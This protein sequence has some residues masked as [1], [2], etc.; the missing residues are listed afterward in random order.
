MKQLIKSLLLIAICAMPAFAM[1]Q[2]ESF[3]V[4]TS[5]GQAT[6]QDFALAYCSQFDAG[7][8]EHQALKGFKNGNSNHCDV[9]IENGYARFRSREYSVLNTLEV[10][11]WNLKKN[12]EKLIAVNRVSEGGDGLDES[13]LEFYRYNAKTGVMKRTKAPFVDAPRPI[14][15]V[16]LSV[17]SDELVHE[18]KSAKN[19][20]A[21][22]YQPIFMLPREGQD[23]TFRMA[24]PDAIPK[25]LQRVCTLIWNGSKFTVDR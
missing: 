7:T 19:E 14:D 15:M 1:A 18:V 13:F 12:N 20:D 11:C 10:C 17:A 9:D 3:E 6:I 16:D 24:D 21:N 5:G 2:P 25:A 4:T 23:I 22:K 8:F